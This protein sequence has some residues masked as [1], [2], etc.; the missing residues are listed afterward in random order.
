MYLE[1][2][3]VSCALRFDYLRQFMLGALWF[4]VLVAVSVH[5]E[6]DLR[7][8]SFPSFRF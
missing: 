4:S 7:V 1:G 3:P 5:D 8:Q 6:I 2:S